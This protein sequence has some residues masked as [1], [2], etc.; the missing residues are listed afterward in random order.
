M[1][2]VY[3]S[4]ATRIIQTEI[5]GKPLE[6]VSQPDEIVRVY[7]NPQNEGCLEWKSLA[8][9]DPQE[10]GDASTGPTEDDWEIVTARYRRLLEAVA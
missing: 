3:P 5:D 1:I 4:E 7:V 10:S 6:L 8:G 2:D 9:M